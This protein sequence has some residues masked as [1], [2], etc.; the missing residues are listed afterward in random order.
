MQATLAACAAAITTRFFDFMAISKAASQRSRHD[1]LL[2]SIFKSF[3]IKILKFV[4]FDSHLQKAWVSVVI[5]IG[6]GGISSSVGP[7]PNPNCSLPVSLHSYSQCF[8]I[9][10]LDEVNEHQG[11]PVN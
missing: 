3:V 10:P 5:M 1:A 2:H 11:C 4:I 7:P 8:K 6:A 9:F